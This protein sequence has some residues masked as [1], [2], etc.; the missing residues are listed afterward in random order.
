[1]DEDAKDDPH[2]PIYF[3]RRFNQFRTE[4]G[5]DFSGGVMY[6]PAKLTG[7]AALEYMQ[8]G[9]T[10]VPA[11]AASRSGDDELLE[12]LVVHAFY[13]A[14]K[15]ADEVWHLMTIYDVEEIKEGES[16]FVVHDDSFEII[17]G[18]QKSLMDISPLDERF[19][20][21]DS[22]QYKKGGYIKTSGRIVWQADTNFPAD[23]IKVAIIAERLILEGSVYRIL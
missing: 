16:L 7:R 23:N 1:M 18:Y 22:G 5:W 13:A 14:G 6:R 20:K 11:R 17:R 3:Q 15:N 8:A 19:V 21:F 2:L 4:R 12:E 10:Q 9:A